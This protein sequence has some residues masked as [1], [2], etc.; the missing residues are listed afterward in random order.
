MIA[1]EISRAD[2]S[3]LAAYVRGACHDATR[4]RAGTTRIGQKELAWVESLRDCIEAAGD[5]AWI[6]REGRDR[7][8][9]IVE[10]SAPYHRDRCLAP[11]GTAARIAYVRGYFDAEGG[12]PHSAGARFYLQIAQKD[13]ACLANLR[14]VIVDLAISCGVL[15]VPSRRV[16]PDY[17]RF[18]VRAAGQ[19][20]FCQLIS[21]WHPRKR[22]LMRARLNRYD[23]PRGATAVESA[24]IRIPGNL[25]ANTG[26]FGPV[27]GCSSG[28]SAVPARTSPSLPG[29]SPTT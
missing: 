27:L 17:W 28:M 10:T 16:D 26:A 5:R 21:S 9:W 6:Y 1:D 12:L 13:Y 23:G 7:E 20:R 4:G 15:H 25:S 22:P 14:Q 8:Y 2:S 24:S 3:V 18:F 29:T 11:E 19:D